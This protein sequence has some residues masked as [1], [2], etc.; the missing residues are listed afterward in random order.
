MTR[1]LPILLC[2]GCAPTVRLCPSFRTRHTKAVAEAIAEAEAI[3]EL[4][5]TTTSRCYGSVYVEFMEAGQGEY[6]GMKAPHGQCRRYIRTEPD[7]V[8]LAHELGHTLGLHHVDP[9]DHPS[10]LMNPIVGSDNTHLTQAQRDKITQEAAL[11]E[12]CRP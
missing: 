2:L 10:N 9:D 3:L 1:L 7:G 5:L 4:E 8:L 12:A 6:A 11:L